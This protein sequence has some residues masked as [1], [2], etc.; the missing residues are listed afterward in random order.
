[1]KATSTPAAR[2][3]DFTGISQNCSLFVARSSAQ[4]HALHCCAENFSFRTFALRKRCFVRGAG[5]FIG[6][7][8]GRV[9]GKG[10]RDTYFGNY[11]L[12]DAHAGRRALKCLSASCSR[13][14]CKGSAFG[15]LE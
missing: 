2:I 5:G 6:G 9:P 4:V 12:T 3:A 10:T 14:P 1:V 8:A 7:N 11:N 15:G 13:T